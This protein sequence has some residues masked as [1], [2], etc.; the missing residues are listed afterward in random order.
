MKSPVKRILSLTLALIMAMSMTIGAMAADKPAKAIQVQLDGQNIALKYA[1]VVKNG[2]TYVD[3]RSVLEAMGAKVSYNYQT[4]VCTSVLNGKTTEIKNIISTDNGPYISLRAAAEA[5]GY[6]IGWDAST[7]TAVLLN[8]DK[9]VAQYKGKFKIM[10]KYLAYS[11][12]LSSQKLAIKGT[13][14]ISMKVTAD[15]TT[16]PATIKGTIDGLS[17]DTLAEMN[18]NMAVDMTD[19]LKSMDAAELDSES[20]AILKELG[21]TTINFIVNADDGIIY[22]KSKLFSIMAGLADNTWISFDLNSMFKEAGLNMTMGSLMQMSKSETFDAYLAALLRAMPL[23]S[24]DASAELIKSLDQMEKMYGDKAITKKD[25]DYIATYSE[26]DAETNTAVKM[27]M[28]FNSKNDKIVGYSMDMSTSVDGSEIMKI[29][30]K[31]DEDNKVKINM[32]L[33]VP[34]VFEAVY[35]INMQYSKTDKTARS[36]PDAGSKILSLNSLLGL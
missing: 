10:D 26:N 12:E 27:T 30:A 28:T 11:R 17:S 32:T 19:L 6:S 36:K 9:I 15:G 5:A 16:T 24:S 22:V 31:Q 20:T 18:M 7:K 13:F 1:P 21:N 8:V 4:N 33:G 23:T 3:F 14:D 29:T 34:N 25:N 35:D 2:T